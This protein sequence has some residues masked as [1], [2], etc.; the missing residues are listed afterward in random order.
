MAPFERIIRRRRDVVAP[1]NDG[2]WRHT[3]IVRSVWLLLHYQD[4]A[5]LGPGN[6]PPQRGIR[7]RGG[8]RVGQFDMMLPNLTLETPA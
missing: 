8:A 5:E 3:G 6:S 7:S 1:P 2:G 4:E